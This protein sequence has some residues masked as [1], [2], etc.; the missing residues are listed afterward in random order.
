MCVFENVDFDSCVTFIIGM[1]SILNG[2]TRRVFYGLV[3]GIWSLVA[4][5]AILHDHY[6][7]R[8]APEHFTVY[9]DNPRGIRDAYTL[10]A[11]IAFIASISPG[12]LL[13]LASWW[14]GRSGVWPKLPV[15]SI[16]RS[17]LIVIGVTEGM[18]V[19]SGMFVVITGAPVYPNAWYPDLDEALVLT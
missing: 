9:H 17:V 7:V 3:F 10:A 14:V 4:V 18:A 12:L 6:L 5:Y 1:K 19:A 13:G 11:W 16:L 2:E 8:I 15:R